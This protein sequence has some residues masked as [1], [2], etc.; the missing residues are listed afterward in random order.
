MKLYSTRDIAASV[1]KA[2]ENF[3]HVILNRGYMTLRP[4]YFNTA[5]LDGLP[6]LQYASWIP[7]TRT[8][9]TRWKNLGGVLIE[10]DNRPPEEFPADVTVMVEC[11]YDMKRLK[12]C[13]W[14]NNE[15]GV[16]PH[17]VSWTTHEECIDLRF[18]TSDLLREIWSIAVGQPF[19]NQELASVTGIPSTK[20]QYIKNSLHPVE[21]WYIQKRLAPEREEMLPAWDWLESGTI[22]KA[23]I[24][25]AG[26]KAMIEELGRFGYIQLK[27]YQHYPKGEPDWSTIDRQRERALIDLASVRSLVNS[28][29]DHLSE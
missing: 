24:S 12:Q 18:P 1:K 8:Q 10:Q 20:L 5:T 27:K 6:V 17:P 25:N 7:A 14:R 26:Y 19:T 16:I 28:L 29:P 23:E 11:P 3:T 15:Y 4:V 22:S 13:M 9:L 21:H 2:Y